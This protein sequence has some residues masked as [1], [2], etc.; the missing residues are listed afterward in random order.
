MDEFIVKIDRSLDEVLIKLGKLM[1]RL[2]SL[3]LT[4]SSEA[5]EA[6]ARSV[7][8]FSVCARR[9]TDPLVQEL[10]EQLEAITKPRLRLVASR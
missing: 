3:Q 6:L 10:A 8:R 4:R 2:S 9:S 1:L 5:R 7:D